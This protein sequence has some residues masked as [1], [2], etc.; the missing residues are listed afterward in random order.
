[1]ILSRYCISYPDP[2]DPDSVILYSTKRASAALIERST[3]TAIENGTLCKDAAETLAG[4]GLLVESAWEERLEALRFLDELNEIDTGLSVMSV[5][6]L[7]CNL[8]CPYCFEGSRRGRHYMSP[9]TAGRLIDFI[10]SNLEKGRDMLGVAFYGGEP[11]LSVDLV[12]DMAGRLKDMAEEKGVNFSFTLTTNGT[13]LTA[14]IVR[15]LKPLGLKM[16]SVTIDGPEEIHNVSRPYAIGAGSFRRIIDNL[17]AV[18]E[19]VEIDIG[20]N[21]REDNYREFPGLLDHLLQQGLTP[22]RIKSIGFVPVIREREGIVSPEFSGGCLSIN[23]PWLFE[24][25]LFLRKEI[26]SRGFPVSAISPTICAIERKWMFIVNYDGSIYKCPGLIGQPEF[27]VG[28]VVNGVADYSAS[29]G[30]DN[31]KKDEC[32]DCVYLPLCFGGCRYVNIL[33]GNAISGLDCRKPFYDAC[34]EGL[35]RQDLGR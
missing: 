15:R 30:L 28:D 11:L 32:L 18:C 12:Q 27:R 5:M 24:A 22:D 33:G 31:W 26:M 1:M 19:D 34:L 4:L 29:H 23:E 25:A 6:N 3:M 14:D 9:E 21:F 13:L 7:D 8:A 35:V 20:G 16:A 17:K 10:G 2:T